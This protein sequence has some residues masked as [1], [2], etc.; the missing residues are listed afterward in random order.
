MET[1]NP[2]APKIHPR[3]TENLNRPV[4]IEV[5]APPHTKSTRLMW[6]HTGFSPID[7]GQIILLLSELFPS[8]EKERH[9]LSFLFLSKCNVEAKT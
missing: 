6:L 4:V 9:F 3:E 8:I 1:Q 7:K 5:R 2:Y